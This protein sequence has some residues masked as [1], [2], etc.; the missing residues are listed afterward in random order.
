VE[1]AQEMCDYHD[2]APEDIIQYNLDKET[3]FF[4]ETSSSDVVK[5][6]VTAVIAI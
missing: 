3:R 2:F 1:T 4:A 6:A 5:I